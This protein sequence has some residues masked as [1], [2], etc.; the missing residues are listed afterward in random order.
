[1]D[2]ANVWR[3]ITYTVQ[4]PEIQDWEPAF[5]RGVAYPTRY[6]FG[7]PRAIIKKERV[8]NLWSENRLEDLL[9]K[10]LLE[11]G[12][13]IGFITGAEKALQRLAYIDGNG[14]TKYVEASD[15]RFKNLET[16]EEK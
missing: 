2:T 10:R 8:E 11:G 7:T 15:A 13:K 12:V 4:P 5:T 6:Q 16:Y 1:V 14:R 3:G 9:G